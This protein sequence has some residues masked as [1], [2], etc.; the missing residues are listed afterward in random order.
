MLRCGVSS[1]DFGLALPRVPWL[2]G[3]TN[4][5]DMRPHHV[6][7]FLH[8]SRPFRVK[9]RRTQCEQ[10]SSGLPLKADIA[11]CSRHVSKVPTGDSCTATS[12]LNFGSASVLISAT[13]WEARYRT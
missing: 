10:M 5:E 2:S 6:Q 12:S 7:F 3:Q 4:A 8:L 9:L 11:L 1:L 13:A